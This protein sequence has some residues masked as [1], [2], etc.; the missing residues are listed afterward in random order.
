MALTDKHPLRG[1]YHGDLV[2]AELLSLSERQLFSCTAKTWVFG[3]MGLLNDVGFNE[4]DQEIYRAERSPVLRD[5][6]R[7]GVHDKRKR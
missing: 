1:F 4:S 5:S 7:L 2:P 6:R 3:G